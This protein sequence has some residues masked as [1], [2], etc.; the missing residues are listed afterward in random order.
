[1]V[2]FMQY[3]VVSVFSAYWKIMLY[4]DCAFQHCETEYEN[5]QEFPTDCDL[6]QMI[7]WRVAPVY[8]HL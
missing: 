3:M 4:V 2:Y 6:L 1:M 7:S 5:H 8:A